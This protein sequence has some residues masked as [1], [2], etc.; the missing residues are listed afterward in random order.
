MTASVRMPRPLIMHLSDA[1]R[2]HRITIAEIVRRA[3]RKYLTACRTTAPSLPPKQRARRCESEATR[4]D[5]IP[6]GIPPA[7]IPQIV[8][9][10]LDAFDSH[11]ATARTAAPQPPGITLL[12]SSGLPVFVFAPG[13]DW[14]E[15]DAP[16]R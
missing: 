8:E 11:Q 3:C 12:D 2:R 9:W 13:A 15:A 5:G 14:R 7:M 4:Y 1:S 6:D 10:Y 16:F